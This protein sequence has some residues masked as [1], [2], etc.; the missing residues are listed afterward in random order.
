MRSEIVYIKRKIAKQ[1]HENLTLAQSY[2]TEQ[3]D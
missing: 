2:N 1:L 3:D